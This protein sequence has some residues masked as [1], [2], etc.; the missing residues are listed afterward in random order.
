MPS[1][2]AFEKKSLYFCIFS[3]FQLKKK[4]SLRLRKFAQHQ[5]KTLQF[6]KSANLE[7]SLP[8]FSIFLNLSD[9]EPQKIWKQRIGAAF[10]RKSF[11]DT[12][13]LFNSFH[14]QEISYDVYQV[15]CHCSIGSNWKKFIDL[16]GWKLSFYQ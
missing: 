3:G 16:S 1:T 11:S 8:I 14:Q 13:N 7:G 12:W 5:R 4:T 10:E 2:I 9:V 6:I 15:E